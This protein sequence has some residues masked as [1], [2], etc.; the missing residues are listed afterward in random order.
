M[1]WSMS[2]AKWCVMIISDVRAGLNGRI[3]LDDSLDYQSVIKHFD[4][5]FLLCKLK[6]YTCCNWTLN[7][8]N[9]NTDKENVSFEQSS[10]LNARR[11]K[12]NV[13][14]FTVVDA[15]PVVS[16]TSRFATTSKWRWSA[17]RASRSPSRTNGN[18]VGVPDCNIGPVDGRVRRRLLLP[19]I[20]A[21][22]SSAS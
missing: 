8:T 13:K 20:F 6:F 15:F 1:C 12:T 11:K 19:T 16:V 18:I 7:A 3:T 22:K 10:L 17:C 21:R 5:H 4:I 2:Y 14:D 9:T